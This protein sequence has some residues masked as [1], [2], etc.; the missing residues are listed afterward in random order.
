MNSNMKSINVWPSGWQANAFC[1][2]DE[3]IWFM[4][5]E[6]NALM[7]CN[8]DTGETHCVGMVAEEKLIGQYLYSNIIQY[9]EK[10]YLIPRTAKKIA[11]YDIGVG[12]FEYVDDIE[13]TDF[14]CS[15]LIGEYIYLIPTHCNKGILVFNVNTL[16]IERTISMAMNNEVCENIA[17]TNCVYDG[18]YLF[19]PTYDFNGVQGCVIRL[20]SIDDSIKLLF[21]NVMGRGFCSIALLRN[22]VYL[23]GHDEKIYIID[24]DTHNLDNVLAGAG[25]STLLLGVLRD[26]VLVDSGCSENIYFVSEDVN[27]QKMVS[28]SLNNNVGNGIKS[29]Q[30]GAFVVCDSYG[31]YFCRDNFTINIVN[32]EGKI[33]KQIIPT[34]VDED[35]KMLADKW[36]EKGEDAVKEDSI[37]TLCG[38]LQALIGV[39]FN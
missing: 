7:K 18:R 37:F 17:G 34:L 9:K 30:A 10:L 11:V 2:I 33:V 1:K 35:I 24:N 6:I 31:I 28:K 22:K 13:E 5:G 29:E 20:D 39:G 27:L 25:K 16:K 4:H 3:Y 14:R 26:K 8:V 32:S 21:K 12:E 19:I 38:M 36:I 23:A 15:C